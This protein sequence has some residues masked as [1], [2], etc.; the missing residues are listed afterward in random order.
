MIPPSV[1]FKGENMFPTET[2]TGYMGFRGRSHYLISHIKV[3]HKILGRRNIPV[4]GKREAPPKQRPH[5]ATKSW[6]QSAL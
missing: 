6:S 5:E 1:I 2:V 4:M 3:A